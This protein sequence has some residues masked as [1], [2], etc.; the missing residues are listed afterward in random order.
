MRVGE[1]LLSTD[2]SGGSIEA[3]EPKSKDRPLKKVSELTAPAPHDRERVFPSLAGFQASADINEYASTK[4][5]DF[6]MKS[7]GARYE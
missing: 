3:I 6:I 5:L 1:F 4:D 2:A 7:R